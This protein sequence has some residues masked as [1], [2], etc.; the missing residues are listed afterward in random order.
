MTREESDQ[1]PSQSLNSDNNHAHVSSSWIRFRNDCKSNIISILGLNGDTESK[2]IPDKLFFQ[3]RQALSTWENK[4]LP[5]IY[6]QQMTSDQSELFKILKNYLDRQWST[7]TYDWFQRFVHE[8][9][10]ISPNIYD[11]LLTRT[12]D[13]GLK[14]LQDNF[15]LSLTIRFLFDVKDQTKIWDIL[16]TQGLQG[17]KKYQ[18]DVTS[19]LN[20][21]L[22]D[23][24]QHVLYLALEDYF[25]KPLIDLFKQSNLNNNQSR[26]IELALNCV[27]NNGWNGLNDEKIRDEVSPNNFNKLIE[28]LPSISNTSPVTFPTISTTT[29]QQQLVHPSPSTEQHI[30]RNESEMK[31]KIMNIVKNLSSPSTPSSPFEVF[32][33]NVIYDESG[34]DVDLIV[35]QK[36]ESLLTTPDIIIEDRDEEEP[37]EANGI[38][39]KFMNKKEKLQLSDLVQAGEFIYMNKNFNQVINKITEDY[40]SNQ[41]FSLFINSCFIPLMYLLKRHQNLDDFIDMLFLKYFKISSS[42][43]LSLSL[44]ML[45]DLLLLRSDLSLSRKILLLL[46]KRNPIPFLQPSLRFVSDIIHIWNYSVPTLLSFG[47][48]S[49]QGKSL[50]LNQIFLSSFEQSVSSLYFE[51]TI[52]IDFGYN[53]LPRRSINIADIHGSIT[54]LILEKVYQLFN[55]FL[56]HVE[57]SYIQNNLPVIHDL[58]NL[59]NN[60]KKYRLLI[61]RDVLNQ[62]QDQC[63]KF[64]FKEFPDIEIFILPNVSDHNKKENKSSIVLL[65]DKIFDQ[66]PKDCLNHPGFMKNELLQLINPQYKQYLIQISQTIK[67]LITH[68]SHLINKPK[69]VSNYL[70]EYLKF[71]KLCELRL[72]LTHLNFYGSDNDAMIYELRQRIFQLENI[73]QTNQRLLSIIYQ[74]FFKVLTAS[75]SLTCLD[76]IN[77]A[78]RQQRIQL[79]STGDMAKELPIE[80]NLSLEVLWRNAIVCSQYES[81]NDQKFLQDKYYQYIKAGYPFEIIDGDNFHFQHSFLLKSLTPFQNR[82]TLVISIIGPQNSGKSTLL[83]YMFGTLF[84]VRDGR[85]TRGIYGSFVKSNRSDYDYILL[86]DTEGLLGIEREDKEYDRRIVLFCLAV[87]HIVIVNMVGE[88]SATLQEMLKLCADSLDKIGATIIP[89]PIVHFILNQKADLNIDNNKAAI[90]KIINDLKREGLDKSIDIRKET[91]HTLPSAF[92]K[93]GQTLIWKKTSLTQIK[94]APEFIENVQLLFGRIFNSIQL[95]DISDPL[96]WLSS[97]VT[98]FETLQKFSDLTYYRNIHEQRLDNQIREHIRETL[99]KMF[100]IDYR[101]ELILETTNKDKDEIQKLFLHKQNQIEKQTQNDLEDLFKLL[102]VPELLRKRN[103]QFLHVQIIEMFHTIQ[104]SAIESNRRLQV[105]SIIHHAEEQLRQLMEHVIQSGRLMLYETA[106][107]EFERM[108]QNT[109]KFVR[110]GF[111]LNERLKQAMKHI[112]TNYNIYEKECL[113]EFSS[114]DTHSSLLTDQTSINNPE[115]V[116]VS[117]FTKL[118]YQKPSVTAHHFNPT[119]IPTYSLDIINSLNYLNRNLLEHE[120]RTFIHQSSSQIGNNNKCQD[121]DRERSVYSIS[122]SSSCYQS[123]E[124]PNLTSTDQFQIQIRQ[125]IENQKPM[126]LGRSAADEQH[127]YLGLSGIIREIIRRIIQTIQGVNGGQVRQIRTE[128]IQKIVGSINTLIIEIKTELSPFCLE[129]SRQLKSTLHTCAI[130]LLTRYYYNEQIN[131]FNQILANFER[132]KSDLKEYFITNVCSNSSRDKNYA[133]NLAQQF[134]D[135]LIQSLSNDGQQIITRGSKQYECLNRKWIQDRLDGQLEVNNNM[136][137]YSDYISNPTKIIEQFFIE[138]WTNVKKEIDQNLSEQKAFYI[139]IINEFFYCIQ[140]MLDSVRHLGAPNKLIDKIFQSN[141]RNASNI[142]DDLNDKNQCMVMILCQYLTEQSIQLS[143]TVNGTVYHIG[144]DAFNAFQLLVEQRRPSNEL[145]KIIKGISLVFKNI[146]I[147]NLIA[148]LEALLTEREKTLHDFNQIPC[149]FD[150]IDQH[151][152]Y[153]RLLDKVRGCPDLCPCCRRPCDVDHTQIKSNPGSLHNEHRCQSGHNLRAMNG[154]KFETTNEPS[155]LMCEQIKDD[156]II[157]IGPRRYQW[158]DFKQNHP[159]WIFESILNDDE[160]NRLHGKFLTIW[161]KIGKEICDKYHMKYVK[162]NTSLNIVHESF[163]YILLLDGSGS[164][165][166]QRWKDLMNAVQQ[167]LI[168]RSELNTCDRISIIVFSSTANIIYSNEDIRNINVNSIC[169][170]GGDTSFRDAFECVSNCMTYS[171]RHA[172][173]HSVHHKFAIVFM[174]D[175]EGLYPDY[176]LKRLIKEHGPVIKR[177]WTLALGINQVSSSMN[178]L[179]KINE[180]MNGSFIDIATSIDLLKAYAEVASFS[181]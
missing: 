79:V 166:G 133:I 34:Y 108:Y 77:T 13:N 76:A 161:R 64:L 85:C 53:F 147:S 55:G 179:E 94:T 145:A 155:L 159:N 181:Q 95:T 104:I 172:A 26:F 167:F 112:Y 111:S 43:P 89:R 158:S 72:K 100:S 82:R 146:S 30:Q 33:T 6:H 70:P 129:L 41:K 115:D 67:P 1:T 103:Q 14:F 68:L 54:K 117:Y 51:N 17:I 92:Q 131:H 106:E 139:K 163:H 75:N 170:P 25:R 42:A 173:H 87:S 24:N 40:K 90:E 10:I 121:T 83:N 2:K 7:T 149:S 110:D 137:W 160:L 98:I 73:P 20:E 50:L 153:A 37:T 164:M 165:S 48:G 36:N 78:L 175:G 35:H 148:F 113:V 59:V 140:G 99:L 119:G 154:Y 63:R 130:I 157:V 180:K 11:Q 144:R 69:L 19:K 49:C 128:L 60:T 22:L 102:K 45:I 71:V 101:N 80:K 27:V 141:E 177:F 91:F 44:R 152:T 96:Q 114:I 62:N 88:V 16:T 47:I 97:S 127:M 120:F 23:N 168:R 171:E 122:N 39:S 86:I 107:Q 65:R 93:E 5:N 18:N 105:S 8:Q 21:K 138:L 116:F 134:K 32:N 176:E 3:G 84:D 118:A 125:A 150:H 38:I 135:Y 31:P 61:I 56:I 66:I 142:N 143:L 57:Y 126:M 29:T 74:L 15:Y 123:R 136:T 151:D 46:S 58:L 162:Y 124:H 12:V 28:N 4:I 132:K 9:K 178:V 81:E 109:I 156:Q 169:Y 52:D 174:S